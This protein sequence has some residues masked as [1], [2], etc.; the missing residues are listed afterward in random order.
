M[1][2]PDSYLFEEDIDAEVYQMKVFESWVKV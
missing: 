1:H 2:I